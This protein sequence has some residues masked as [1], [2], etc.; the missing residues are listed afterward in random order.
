MIDAYGDPGEDYPLS[1][2]NRPGRMARITVRD[3]LERVQRWQ[4]RYTSFVV[5][6]PPNR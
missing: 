6:P 3:V 1:M 4:E 5:S 2:E